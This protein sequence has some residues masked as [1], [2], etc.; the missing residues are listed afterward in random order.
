MIEVMPDGHLQFECS[1]LHSN[2]DFYLK[3]D[4]CSKF[5]FVLT[6]L[7]YI[8][9]IFKTDVRC[10]CCG[11]F[12]VSNQFSAYKLLY[13]YIFYLLIQIRRPDPHSTKVKLLVSIFLFFT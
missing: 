7:I 8:K 3:F 9:K 6:A 2:V 11:S 13:Y 5:K 10:N 4:E 12:I 1:V